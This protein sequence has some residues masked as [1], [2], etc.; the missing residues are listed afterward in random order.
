MAGRD[1]I[2]IRI[3]CAALAACG[4][5]D[6]D[7]DAVAVSQVASAFDAAGD[8]AR[9]VVPLEAAP[10]LDSLTPSA[11]EMAQVSAADLAFRALVPPLQRSC[12]TS[13]TTANSLTIAFRSCRIFLGLFELDGSLSATVQI[14]VDGD[15]RPNRIT[16]RVSSSSMTLSGPAH[17]RSLAG[18]FALS[19][20]IPA[21][22]IPVHVEGD[23]EV[24]VDNEPAVALSV[25][26]DWEVERAGA[27]GNCVTFT[28]GA[29]LSAASLAG[30]PIA[31]SGQSIVA[32]RDA[33]PQ[34]GTAQLSYGRGT[35]LAWDYSGSDTAVV[36]G[37]RGASF[38]VAL[39]CAGGGLD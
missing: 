5:T 10:G 6:D 29:D 33:C 23:L 1:L 32:C 30:S 25:T 22:E 15:G 4:P 8:L 13:S 7:D 34:S 26:A 27:D 31:L 24:T 20:P 2:L 11:A 19:Q 12:I 14:D 18:S 38:E 16:T 9:V 35:L 37:T 39:P 21:G 28:G 3:A 36:T 17:T